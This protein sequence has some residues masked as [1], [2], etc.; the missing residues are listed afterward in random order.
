MSMKPALISGLLLVNVTAY[1][2]QTDKL[3][4][5]AG[6]SFEN[7]DNIYHSTANKVD[8]TTIHTL[9]T[10]E[11][12][13]QSARL[14]ALFNLNADYH[15]Y[16]NHTFANRTTISSY[17]SLNA[18]LAKQRLFWD[19]DD[20][21]DRVQ[22]NQA[23]ANIPSN[24]EDTNHFTTGP[25]FVFFKDNKSSLDAGIKYEKFY[26]ETSNNDYSGYVADASY[27]RNITHTTALG[28]IVNYSDRKF[29]NSLLNADYTRTDVTLNLTKQM[30][31]STL[32]VDVGKTAFKPHDQPDTQQSI[33]RAKY[34]YR[35]GEKTSLNASYNRELSDFST[36]FA[37]TTPGGT[38]YA[39]V[40]GAT[41]LLKMGRLSVIRNF[42]STSLRY[43]YIYSSNDYSI[44]TLDIITR[45]STL[46]LSN[47]IST[48]LTLDLSGL[49]QDTSYASGNRVDLARVYNLGVTQKF[50]N[51]Y[52]LTFNIQY[53]NNDSTD[54][55]YSY[56]ERRFNISGSY[57]FR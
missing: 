32:E 8:E 51:S 53:T 17:L 52:D 44:N 25:R 6:L 20:R 56:D 34:Q 16:Q 55:I 33:F 9:L 46:S 29:D 2:A 30:R 18:T 39:N 13:R 48:G 54:S 50:L 4:F 41:F 47:N 35:L 14:N 24:Q 38:T 21:F 10:T 5:S 57:Y 11:Y 31:L 28:L 36:M 27:I 43:D 19:I 7:S 45:A 40:S 37:A 26:T 22:I 49:Y 42:S 23:V 12:Q 3:A 1:A 15:D